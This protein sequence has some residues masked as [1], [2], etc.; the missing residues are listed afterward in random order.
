[1]SKYLDFN[2]LKLSLGLNVY[3]LFNIQN[4]IDLYPETGDAAIRSEYYMR[5]VK[6]PE[7]SGTKSN[8]YY[9]NPWHYGTPREINMFMRIDFR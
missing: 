7:D 6:L 3:N 5:E 2:D 9:D 8:S 4:V 1:F